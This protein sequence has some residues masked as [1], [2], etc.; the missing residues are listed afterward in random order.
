MN[1]ILKVCLKNPHK[2]RMQS[3]LNGLQSS[4]DTNLW[5][6][7]VVET[8]SGV[9]CYDLDDKER[10]LNKMERLKKRRIE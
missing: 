4:K 10:L 9:F 5:K 1:L 2:D 7:I 3:S 8:D 6:K